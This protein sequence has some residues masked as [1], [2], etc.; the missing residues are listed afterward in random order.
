MTQGVRLFLGLL[1]SGLSLWIVSIGFLGGVNISQ[2]IKKIADI[3][4]LWASLAIGF[5]MLSYPLNAMRLRYLLN[6]DAVIHCRFSQVLPIVW[7]SSFLSLATPSAAFSDAI[8]AALLRAKKISNLSLA[9]RAVLID[10][11]MGLIYT[12]VLAG[13]LLLIVPSDLNPEFS[14]YMGSI[15]LLGSLVAVVV[16]F[17]GFKLIKKIQFLTWLHSPLEDIHR[18]MISPKAITIFMIFAV[19]N[20]LILAFSLWFISLSFSVDA[21]F[22]MFFMLTPVILIVNNLPVFYQ[23]FG[24]REGVMLFA[25]GGASTGISPDVILTISLISGVA[26]I[27]SALFGS[28]FFPMLLLRRNVLQ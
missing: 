15:F 24:G 12:L 5:L 20:A 22:F 8:R 19:L 6:N 23:G 17:F 26:M 11:A 27:I 3:N 25:L 4:H 18:L 13:A 9:I 14:N 1:V 28:L 2:A 21:N 16:I 7:V 10:R